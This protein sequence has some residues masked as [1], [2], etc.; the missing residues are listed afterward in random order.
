MTYQEAQNAITLHNGAI[1]NYLSGVIAAAA[2]ELT[3]PADKSAAAWFS[4]AEQLHSKRM[5]FQSEAVRLMG[6]IQAAGFDCWLYTESNYL[7]MR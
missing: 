1:S 5:V 4:L 6:E 2:D 7:G 3:D